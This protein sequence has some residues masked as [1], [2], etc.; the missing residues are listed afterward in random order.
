MKDPRA[1]TGERCTRHPGDVAACSWNG[2]AISTG[3]L[4]IAVG[5]QPGAAPATGDR[6][7]AQ[8]IS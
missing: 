8:E 6:E 5:E 4:A 2:V 7:V 3:G 1:V